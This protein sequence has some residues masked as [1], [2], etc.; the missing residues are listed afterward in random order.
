[1]TPFGDEFHSYRTKLIAVLLRMQILSSTLQ[2]SMVKVCP[3]N[4]T[5]VEEASKR[6]KCSSGYDKTKNEHH[7]VPFSNFTH[8]VEF[9][10]PKTSG[11]IEH[12]MYSTTP[13]ILYLLLCF[14][15]MLSRKYM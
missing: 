5:E 8:L 9:C 3:E 4:E 2:I 12:G 15:F 6:L 1:M 13:F 14:I 7:C 10:Y 11:L